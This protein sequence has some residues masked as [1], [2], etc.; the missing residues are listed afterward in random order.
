MGKKI[1]LISVD[2]V[3]DEEVV[4][5]PAMVGSIAPARGEERKTEDYR[6]WILPEDGPLLTGLRT[7][8]E[9]MDRKAYSAVPVEREDTIRRWPPCWPGWPVGPLC[10]EADPPTRFYPDGSQVTCHLYH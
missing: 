9:V 5:H 7:L 3:P 6:S 2:E 8:E 10:D 4:I 1:R